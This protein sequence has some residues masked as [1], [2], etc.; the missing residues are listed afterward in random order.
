MNLKMTF[1]TDHVREQPL[2]NFTQTLKQK[3][4]LLIIRNEYHMICNIS[5][6][7]NDMFH[8]ICYEN[9]RI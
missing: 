9:Q 8:M 4:D 5:Y 7:P 3:N 6:I 2:K 1:M